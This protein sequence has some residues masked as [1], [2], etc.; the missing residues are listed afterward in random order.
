M[1]PEVGEATAQVLR[2]AGYRMELAENVC[3]GLP[4][5]AYGDLASASLLAAKNLG[6]FAGHG[7]I[8]T[9]CGSCAS[10]LKE[11]PQLF[12]DGAPAHVRSGGF[13][14]ADQGRHGIP[15]QRRVAARF[16]RCRG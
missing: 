15:G 2:A 3:C 12:E 11:Y 13:L 10:F 7:E 8:L 5:Y 9:D 4:P 6:R 14:A 1:V 16:V